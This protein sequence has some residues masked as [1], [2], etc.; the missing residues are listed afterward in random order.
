MASRFGSIT[1][2]ETTIGQGTPQS[3]PI[4]LDPVP[5]VGS[6]I[7]VENGELRYSNG[8]SWLEVGT[9]CLQGIT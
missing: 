4:Q 3:F 2:K 6:I 7:Y 8:T 9:G 5:Y 1:G